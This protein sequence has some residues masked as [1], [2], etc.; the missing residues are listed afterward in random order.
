MC[1]SMSVCV[2]RK[3]CLDTFV[4]CLKAAVEQMNFSISLWSVTHSHLLFLFLSLTHIMLIFLLTLY[5]VLITSSHVY[6]QCLDTFLDTILCQIA[7]VHVRV[8]TNIQTLMSDYWFLVILLLFSILHGGTSLMLRVFEHSWTTWATTPLLII[9][10]HLSGDTD[11]P[12]LVLTSS[13]TQQSCSFQICALCFVRIVFKQCHFSISNVILEFLLVGNSV[14][15]FHVLNRYGR[16]FALHMC[17]R[18]FFDLIYLHPIFHINT[19]C[20]VI[21]VEIWQWRNSK[22]EWAWVSECVSQWASE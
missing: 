16:S 13:T 15:V 17:A 9:A 20:L 5:C 3:I 19:S 10:F 2:K 14:C 8:S 1:T 12:T 22:G 21:H 11:T 6:F 7:C 4:I 18:I